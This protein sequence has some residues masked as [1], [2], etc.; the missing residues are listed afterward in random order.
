MATEAT[1]GTRPSLPALLAILLALIAGL[2]AP[3]LT[4][5]QA[6]PGTIA[7]AGAT[8]HSDAAAEHVAAAAEPLPA[9]VEV[10]H[11]D[12]LAACRTRVL[13]TQLVVAVRAARA[14]PAVSV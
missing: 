12:P 10:V 6:G 7:S 9:P 2:S 8:W 13:R 5:D 1:R 4:V 14:P 3:P 11:R